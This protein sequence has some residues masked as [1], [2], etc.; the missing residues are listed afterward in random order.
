MSADQARE[1]KESFRA[2]SEIIWR[3]FQKPNPGSRE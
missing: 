1:K 3:L 2:G